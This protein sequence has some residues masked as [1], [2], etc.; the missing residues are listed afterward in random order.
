[1]AVVTICAGRACL[2]RGEIC[3][4]RL[5]SNSGHHV[6]SHEVTGA[7]IAVSDEMGIVKQQQTR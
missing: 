5:F 3:R 6:G 4:V 1:M 2:R 7:Q